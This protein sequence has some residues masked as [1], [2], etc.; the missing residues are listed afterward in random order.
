MEY[1]NIIPNAKQEILTILEENPFLKA[2]YDG[3]RAEYEARQQQANGEEDEEADAE[4]AQ[5]GRHHQ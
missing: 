3:Q 1:P 4:G 2:M 5:A